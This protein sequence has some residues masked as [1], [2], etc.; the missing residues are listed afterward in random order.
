MSTDYGVLCYT[1]RH[2]E[3]LDRTLFVTFSF[4]VPLLQ[5][6][7]DALIDGLNSFSPLLSRFLIQCTSLP[8]GQ[9]LAIKKLVAVA[10]PS[11]AVWEAKNVKRGGELMG[12]LSFFAANNSFHVSRQKLSSE[13]F[14]GSKRK[15]GNGG[16]ETHPDELSNGHTGKRAL[17]SRGE[18]TFQDVYGAEAL[19]NEEDEEDDSVVET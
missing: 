4:E 19:L 11:E 3:T 10:P 17:V 5:T 14:L 2:E 18:L 8:V 12:V 9:S 13:F 15:H 6:V 7:T 1:N 16:E